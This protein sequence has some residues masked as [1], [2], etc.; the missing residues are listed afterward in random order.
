MSSLPLSVKRASRKFFSQRAD[1]YRYIASMIES[2]KGNI[3]II[4]LF[5]RDAQ[6]F[7][8]KPR[9][10]LA[11]YW[12]SIYLE[13]G[14]NLANTF[15]DTLPEDELMLLRVAQDAGDGA[16]LA[17]LIDISRIAVLTDRINKEVVGTLMA[18]SIGA[19]I[20]IV[21]ITIFP[22]FSAQK[23]QEIY[24]FIPTDQWGPNGT[25]LLIHAERVKSY[26]L[27][28]ILSIVA[29]LIGFKWT[30]NN[31]IGNVRDW[32]DSHVS[33]YKTIRD[34]KG[35][36][37]LLIMATLTRKRG[38]VMYTLG[39]SL[40]TLSQSTKS[41]WLK[42][43]FDEIINRIEVMGAS[44]ADA[45]DTNIISQE[46]YF[47]L[48]DTQEARGISEGFTETGKF[49][50]STIID[51]IIKNMGIYRWGLLIFGVACVVGIIAWQFSVIYEM[52]NVMSTFY[53]SK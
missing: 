12:A 53:S 19:I 6:R 17:A 1:Y 52:K 29:L 47:F 28:V 15:E 50:E 44:A 34:I 41:P 48:R 11:E 16:L 31:L 2:S 33:I 37:F 49:V 24:S 45:F 21:M 40:S 3:K 18:A 8:G 4:T 5:E 38:N 36:R 20:S 51:K 35:A 22:V 10:I 27:Y 7:E 23:L 25:A 14:S 39:S 43:R 30:I 32:L 42:W 26:G 46:M 13:N 9:G